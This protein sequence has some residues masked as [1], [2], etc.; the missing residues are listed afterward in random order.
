MGSLTNR[1][2][3]LLADHLFNDAYTPVATIFLALASADPTDAATG[4]SFNELANIGAYARATLTFGAAASRAITQ[5]GAVLFATA[6]TAW[7]TAA[8]W[9]V[10][11][12]STYGTGDA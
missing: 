1:A 11:N 8:Y 2:E 10:L 6:T 4:S 7:T 3:T 5:T 12:T 9:A